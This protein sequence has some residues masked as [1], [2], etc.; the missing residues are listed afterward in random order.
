MVQRIK[1]K[2]HGPQLA[3]LSETTTADIQMACNIF[4][5]FSYDKAMV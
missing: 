2:S 4:F 5:Q 3:H 1:K